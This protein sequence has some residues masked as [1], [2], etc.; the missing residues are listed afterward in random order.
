MWRNDYDLCGVH[1]EEGMEVAIEGYPDI[2][3]PSGRL[4]MR[5]NT[6]ELVGEGAL[7]RAYEELKKKLDTEGVFA[8]ERKK[9]LKEYP[10]RIGLITS[11]EGA[12]IHDFLNNLGRHGFSIKFINSR[13]EG[14]IAVQELMSAIWS[15]RKKDIDVLVII[16]G[17]GSLESLQAFNNEMLVREITKMPFPVICGIGHHEDA[18]L[19]TLAADM[20]TSTPTAVTKILNASWEHALA[21]VERMQQSIEYACS[22]TLHQENAKLEQSIYTIEQGFTRIL[23]RFKNAYRNVYEK[24]DLVRSYLDQYQYKVQTAQKNILAVC[25]QN[26]RN[27]KHAID[28]AEKTIRY[29]DPQRALKL[30]YSLIHSKGKLLRS[31]RQVDRGDKLDILLEDGNVEAQAISIKQ[32]KKRS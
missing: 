22:D 32:S 17:G 11:K 18:P 6:V 16:R 21:K 29:N 28:T 30:G 9:T 4:S 14:Q 20:A 12:V 26:L 24:I 25:L 1:L 15:F 31:I 8:E 2:Y 7:K 3:K 27:T 23:E 5:V 19:M 10:H 13:V